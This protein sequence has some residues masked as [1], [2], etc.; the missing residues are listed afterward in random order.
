MNGGSCKELGNEKY[1]CLCA[2]K[3]IGD[4]CELGL[5]FVLSLTT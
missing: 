5:W 3:Y 1:Q 2:N 4:H